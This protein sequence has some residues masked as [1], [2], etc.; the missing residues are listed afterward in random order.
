MK[1]SV[2]DKIKEKNSE[3]SRELKISQLRIFVQHSPVLL[4]GEGPRH[5]PVDHL[6]P[7]NR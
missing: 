2:M 1:H 3:G 6:L 4:A 5:D 7:K